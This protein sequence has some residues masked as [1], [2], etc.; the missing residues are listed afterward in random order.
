MRE[1]T[2]QN[3]SELGHFLRSEKD[4]WILFSL[5][6]KE[7]TKDAYTFNRNYLRNVRVPCGYQYIYYDLKNVY[8]IVWDT[9]YDFIK[10]CSRYTATYKINCLKEIFCGS[11]RSITY[12]FC[13]VFRLQILKMLCRNFNALP[14]DECFCT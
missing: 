8:Y 9:M 2:D 14:L 12:C 5:T 10:Y 7:V 3:N 13:I 6:R 4:G 11:N 1:N